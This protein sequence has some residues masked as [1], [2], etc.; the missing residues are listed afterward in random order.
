MFLFALKVKK[1]NSDDSSVP[2]ATLLCK[3]LQ[4]LNHLPDW[5]LTLWR[6]LLP[7][8]INSLLES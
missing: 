6:P 3:K 5:F 4:K 8:P 2:L 1:M 7:E